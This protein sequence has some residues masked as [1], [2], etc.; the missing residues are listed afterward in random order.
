[1]RRYEYQTVDI[2]FHMGVFKQGLPD[3]AAALNEH[4]REGWQ[5]KEMIL[6]SSQFGTSDRIVAVLERAM[7]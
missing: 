6:P 3:I 4:G 7:E 1:M 5:L 2:S